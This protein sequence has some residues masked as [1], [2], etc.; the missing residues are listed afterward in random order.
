ML[1]PAS[2]QERNTNVNDN[3][4]LQWNKSANANTNT[5]TIAAATDLASVQNNDF[6]STLTGSILRDNDDLVV[7]SKSHE[8]NNH[9][10]TSMN[11]NTDTNHHNNDVEHS[12]LDTTDQPQPFATATTSNMTQQTFLHPKAD[13]FTTID[14]MGTNSTSIS[15]EF[16]H[17]QQQLQRQ[18]HESNKHKLSN[19]YRKN[20]RADTNIN[21]S[22]SASAL[23]RSTN[24]TTHTRAASAGTRARTKTANNHNTS[25]SVNTDIRVSASKIRSR[26]GTSAPTVSPTHRRSRSVDLFT[27]ANALYILSARGKSSHIV[28]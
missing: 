14:D 10:N 3:L 21:K 4:S 26:K 24:T 13:F 11:A 7:L 16:D 1:V 5:T 22:N 9:S 6:K 25:S 17:Y 15:Q 18:Q 28:R 19:P 8:F 20:S 27:E 12:H 2:L 23:K